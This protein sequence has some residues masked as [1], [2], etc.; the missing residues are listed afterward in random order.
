[1]AVIVHAASFTIGAKGGNQHNSAIKLSNGLIRNGHLVL[2][3]SE[4]DVARANTVFGHRKLGGARVNR[5][6]LDF[7]R[8]HQPDLLML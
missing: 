3:F 2:N 5:A 7:C 4:R 8:H 1:M 6:L